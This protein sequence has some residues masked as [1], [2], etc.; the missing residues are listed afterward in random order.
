MAKHDPSLDT[1]FTALGDPTRRAILA[2]LAQG[3]ASVSELAQPF[4]MALPSFMGH[5]ARLE[6]AGLVSTR[7]DGR[8]RTCAMTPGAL[9]PAA[10]WIA[11]QRAIWEA[12]LDR[13]DD[14]VL[15]LMK[16]RKE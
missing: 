8:I 16:E 2:R 5:I 12:R 15:S 3:P 11:E 4:D 14:F 6:A 1:L 9:D 13:L 10:D 7:K